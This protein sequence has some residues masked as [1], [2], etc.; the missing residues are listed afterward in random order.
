MGRFD[1][2]Y[3]F[4]TENIAG[5]MRD[6]DLTGKKVV[7]VTG[8]TDHIINI[9]ARGAKEILTFDIN[10]L[11]K[12]YM[13]LK[14]SA[15][16]TLSFKEFVLFLLFDSPM[17]FAY[18]IIKDLPLLESSKRYWLN[19]LSTFNNDGLLLKHSSIFNL[20]YFLT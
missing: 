19:L 11:V 7:T 6:L 5:Y 18:E 9:V 2:I 12:E 14:L 4:T 13:D 16:R 8:S 3:L 15:I 20:K 10:P 17:S 1:S